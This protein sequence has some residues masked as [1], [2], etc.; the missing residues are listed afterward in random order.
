ME[1][2]MKHEVKILYTTN[3]VILYYRSDITDMCT[4]SHIFFLNLHKFLIRTRS[5]TFKSN[6]VPKKFFNQFSVFPH[7]HL[8][9][10]PILSCYKV[11]GNSQT[12]ISEALH[13]FTCFHH[14]L[15]I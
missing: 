15:H 5:S 13:Y 12:A 9:H 6:T 11:E 1:E 10:R 2:S 3:I 14:T 7:F 8:I 4:I